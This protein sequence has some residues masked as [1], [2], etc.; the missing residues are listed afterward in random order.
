[1]N[2]RNEILSRDLIIL[3]VMM[4]F[5]TLKVKENPFLLEKQGGGEVR[6]DT[7][8]ENEKKQIMFENNSCVMLCEKE[9]YCL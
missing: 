9:L 5:H 3:E 6:K 1:M 7:A 4:I 2:R 8:E